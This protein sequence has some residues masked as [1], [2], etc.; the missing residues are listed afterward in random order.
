M[1]DRD[2]ETHPADERGWMENRPATSSSAVEQ[3]EDTSGRSIPRMVQGGYESL[4]SRLDRRRA[5]R[6]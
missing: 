3:T 5:D 2:R 4:I 6:G 1:A